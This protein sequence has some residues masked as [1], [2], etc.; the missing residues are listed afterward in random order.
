MAANPRSK[1]MLHEAV[2]A[3]ETYLLAFIR[4]ARSSLDNPGQLAKSR[5]A[6]FVKIDA[7]MDEIDTQE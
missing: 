1:E 7:I 5:E 2:E 4:A 6:M 3:V